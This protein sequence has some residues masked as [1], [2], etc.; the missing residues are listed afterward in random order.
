M[1]CDPVIQHY[2]RTWRAQARGES[3][4][5]RRVRSLWTAC[6]LAQATAPNQTWRLAVE[7]EIVH[8]K[9]NFFANTEQRSQCENGVANYLQHATDSWPQL[10]LKAA[11]AAHGLAM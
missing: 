10:H 11:E 5:V 8:S 9:W 4:R 3:R 6:V 7:K 2:A 1:T